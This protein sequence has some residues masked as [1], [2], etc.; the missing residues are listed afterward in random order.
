[1]DAKLAPVSSS[2]NKQHTCSMKGQK[3]EDGEPLKLKIHILLH[4]DN[5]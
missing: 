1:V 5:S 3:Y 2:K 4:G